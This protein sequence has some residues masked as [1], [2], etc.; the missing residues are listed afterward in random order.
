MEVLRADEV[1]DDCNRCYCKPHH[2]FRLEVR[3]HA[4]LFGG[5]LYDYELIKRELTED[6]RRTSRRFNGMRASDRDF[7]IPSHPVLFS[8]VRNDGTRCCCDCGNC[9]CLNCCVCAPMCMDGV[10]VYAG[11]LE[12][13]PLNEKGE[14]T[15]QNGRPHNLPPERFIGSVTQPL[16]GGC[17]VP[18]VFLRGRDA[19]TME[20]KETPFGTI[21]GPCIFGGWAELCCDS[22]FSMSR[23]S[24]DN[25]TGPVKTGD[26]GKLVKQAPEGG[27]SM[28]RECCTEAD[29]YRLEFPKDEDIGRNI[30]AAEKLTML[31]AHLLYDYMLFEGDTAKCYCNDGGITCNFFYCS[32]IGCLVPCS[33]YIP[34]GSDEN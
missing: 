27:I 10:R 16:F 2:P 8:I 25:V 28:L 30:T 1:S 9:K 29:V 14:T 3:E 11:R 19:S 26:L 7:Q 13:P 20:E 18:Q 23:Y 4:Q 12:D 22:T 5:R 6:I 34:I 17:C 15:G 21:V 31:S 24:G 32:I 33:L